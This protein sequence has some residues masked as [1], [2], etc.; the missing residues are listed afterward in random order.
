[1]GVRSHVPSAPA[2]VR[3]RR[4]LPCLADRLELTPNAKEL[5]PVDTSSVS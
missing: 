4:Q 1:M 5:G 2:D 3:E